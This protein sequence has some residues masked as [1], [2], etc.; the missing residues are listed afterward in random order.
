MNDRLILNGIKRI[1][2]LTLLS[3]LPMVPAAYMAPALAQASGEM[4]VAVPAEPESLTPRNGC[5][6]AS[7]F[8]TDNVYERLTRRQADGT[9]AGWLAES[10]EQI[11]PLTWRFKLREGISFTNG[12][13]LNAD[14]VVASVNY[15][16]DPDIASR[17]V[18]DFVTLES[19]E[20]VD[21]YTVDV[22]TSLPDP[23]LDIGFGLRFFVMPP[24]W[25]AETPD[26]VTS[27]SAVGTGP[28]ILTEF[29][30]GESLTLEAN[31]DYWGEPKASIQ[32]IRLIPRVE[33]AVRAAMVQAGEA[34]VAINLTADQT[35][36]LPRSL[37]EETTETILIRL[38]TQHP[39]LSDVRVRKAITLAIDTDLIIEALFPGVASPVNG[40]PARSSALG[41]NPD[42]EPYPYDLEEARRLVEEAGAVGAEIK[43]TIRN[44]LLSNV[45]ELAEAIQAM[46]DQTGL[47]ITLE[48]LEAAPWRDM[49]Y[50]R[51]E[52]Q[53][54]TEMFISGASNFQFDSSR[55][56]NNYYGLGNF[57]HADS[58]E[59][60]AKSAEVGALSGAERDAGYRELWA[61]AREHYWI[62]P[63]FGI[64]FLHGASE[65]VNW[66]PRSDNFIYFNTA[67]LN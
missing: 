7:Q 10:Y 36:A 45:S 39:V 4:V 20:R 11:D 57:S 29:N 51:G 52:G 30:R 60:A 47:R 27:T 64:D 59:F 15:Y 35:A 9:I 42:L 40:H 13:P 46:V 43:F 31:P 28:Y 50:S 53:Q 6:M 2:R 55:L 8:V 19:A 58:E 3:M 5:S 67:T 66:E 24:Q 21:E 22:K 12:E 44:D 33:G 34:D 37:S 41:H 63:L 32:T 23:I 65:R 25:L 26:T 16:V 62:I 48:P 17:C 14:A 38:N 61:E 49:L 18:G 54:R 56:I 1:G